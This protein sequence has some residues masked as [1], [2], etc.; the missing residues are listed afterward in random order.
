M[1]TTPPNQNIFKQ[2]QQG[3]DDDDDD[4]NDKKR[5]RPK[6]V[7]A[8]HALCYG[9]NSGCIKIGLLATLAGL[10]IFSILLGVMWLTT[11]NRMNYHRFS[12]MATEARVR[13][14]VADNDLLEPASYAF[15]EFNIDYTQLEVRWK[16]YDVLGK[17]APDGPLPAPLESIDIHGPLSQSHV[18]NAPTVLALGIGKDSRGR[19]SGRIEI[20]GDLATDILRRS[21][22][23]YISFTLEGGR[24]VARDSLDKMRMIAV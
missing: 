12:V 2:Q 13:P 7:S 14:P 23:Y 10:I 21:Y 6:P 19:F 1:T 22:L 5:R 8:W 9:P 4:D 16:L 24:E 17:V 18:D 3:A 15:G 11:S 20:E